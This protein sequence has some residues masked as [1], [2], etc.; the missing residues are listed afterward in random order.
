MN[1]TPPPAAIPDLRGEPLAATARRADEI[2]KR[3]RRE[4]YEV[5]VAAFGSSI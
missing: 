4:Q 1:P 2:L 3:V 5:P